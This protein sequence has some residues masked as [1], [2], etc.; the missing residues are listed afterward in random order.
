MKT[1]AI[2]LLSTSALFVAVG[3][4]GA[5]GGSGDQAVCGSGIAQVN[6]M[7]D[8]GGCASST[9]A[10]AA[11]ALFTTAPS[12]ITLASGG[13]ATYTVGGGTAP[14]TVTSGNTSEVT[15]SLTGKA[16]TI[17]GISTTVTIGAIV[18]TPVPVAIVDSTGKSVTIMVTVLAMGQV[19]ISP[20]IFPASITVGDCTT[21]IPFVFTGG[22]APFT[23]FTSDNFGVPVSGALPLGPDSY[24]TASIHNPSLTIATLTVLDGQSRTAVA[25]ITI[26][27]FHSCP[28]NPLLQTIPASANLRVTEI[29]AFQVSGGPTPAPTVAPYHTFKFSDPSIATVVM[30]SSTAFNVQAL[31][32]GTTLLTVTS[33]DGQNANIPISVY[34]QPVS[35]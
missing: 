7:L 30:D 5:C 16:L 12:A 21:N 8:T 29:L 1:N 34:L 33:T 18:E 19:G 23:V 26:P 10:T 3:L 6:T 31:K 2:K 14:Y 11:M 4:L 24:F 32:T 13:S 9:T 27:S 22:T 15:T 28:T 35:P 20:S 25:N 17:S